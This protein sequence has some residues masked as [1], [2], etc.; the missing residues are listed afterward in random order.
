LHD[1]KYKKH[2]NDAA[3]TRMFSAYTQ[4]L[5]SVKESEKAD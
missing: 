3:R 2:P 5:L 1:P 4:P